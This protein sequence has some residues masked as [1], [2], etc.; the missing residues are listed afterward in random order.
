[1]TEFPEIL[2][3]GDLELR[4]VP[5]KFETANMVYSVVDSNREHFSEFL[6]WVKFVNS[7]EDQFEWVAKSAKE[8]QNYLIY[9][10]GKFVGA[11]GLPKCHPEEGKNW[12]EIGYWLDRDFSGRGIMTRAVKI[13]EDMLFETGGFNRI[14][15]QID[16]L[17]EAS[18][19][20]AEKAGYKLEGTLRAYD[21]MGTKASGDICVYS[22]LKSEWKK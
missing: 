22:K 12:A 16:D 2:K 11:I 5:K 20:V 13:L 3:D 21:K 14:Q 10:D 6:G 8:K 18:Q 7:A 1:M 9:I 19:R 15:I 17:N 4:V